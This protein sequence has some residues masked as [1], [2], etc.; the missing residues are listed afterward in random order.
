MINRHHPSQLALSPPLL[1]QP[2]AA[3][4]ASV[5]GRWVR[6][7]GGGEGRGGEG[8]RE[9]GREG[10][11]KRGEGEWVPR[12]LVSLEHAGVFAASH[13]QVANGC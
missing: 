3:I 8:R 1:A 6:V 9:G 10:G 2:L 5:N 7:E 4:F 13:L 12:P 11:R